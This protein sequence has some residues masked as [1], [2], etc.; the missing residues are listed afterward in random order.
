V[1]YRK[2]IFEGEVDFGGFGINNRRSWFAQTGA[3]YRFSR[4]FTLG[5]GWTFLDFEGEKN[6]DVNTMFLGMQLTGPTLTAQF[7]F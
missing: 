4:L 1:V 7:S 6:I 2:W 5:A 3:Y